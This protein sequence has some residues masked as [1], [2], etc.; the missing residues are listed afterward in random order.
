M[1]ILYNLSG[2]EKIKLLF[3]LLIILGICSILY[4]IKNKYE[5]KITNKIIKKIL[6]KL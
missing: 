4:V 1:M 5:D 2:E 3:F 6:K